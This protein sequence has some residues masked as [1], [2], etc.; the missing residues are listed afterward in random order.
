MFIK[1]LVKKLILNKP[2]MVK[3]FLK[4]N[5]HSSMNIV[6]GIV[7]ETSND[8]GNDKHH[9][10]YKLAL[11]LYNERNN[12][13]YIDNRAHWTNVFSERGEQLEYEVPQK[14]VDSLVKLSLQEYYKRLK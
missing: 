4:I 3:L 2:A 13:I 1:R 6:S 14:V 12:L 7:V 10:K 5:Y 9:L 11:A 8:A